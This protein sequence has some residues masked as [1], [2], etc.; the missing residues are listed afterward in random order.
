MDTL[1]AVT[2][3][4]KRLRML[5]WLLVGGAFVVIGLWKLNGGQWLPGDV[6]F[7]WL[8][9]VLGSVAILLPGALLLPGSWYLRAEPGGL[10]H[11]VFFK[12]RFYRWPDIRSITVTGVGTEKRVMVGFSGTDHNVRTRAFSPGLYGVTLEQLVDVLN[13]YRER[14]GAV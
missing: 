13:R 4:P 1:T 7:G 14:Y 12:I 10:T 8:W 6:S 2:L 9:V 11:C 3:R 5:G